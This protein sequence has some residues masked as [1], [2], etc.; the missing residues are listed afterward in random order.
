MSILKEQMGEAFHTALR[1][2]CDSMWSSAIWNAFHLCPQEIYSDFIEH[3]IKFAPEDDKVTM[4]WVKLMCDSWDMHG[5]DYFDETRELKWK[6]DKRTWAM[7]IGCTLKIIP[8]DDAE[9]IASFMNYC[10]EYEG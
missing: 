4:E 7:V 8:D 3:L 5:H 2:G 9:G 1:K 10:V 6:G